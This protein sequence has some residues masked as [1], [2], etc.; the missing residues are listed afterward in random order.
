MTILA[1][2]KSN[3]TFFTPPRFIGAVIDHFKAE[4]LKPVILKLFVGILV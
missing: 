4:K 3:E 1:G 2:R